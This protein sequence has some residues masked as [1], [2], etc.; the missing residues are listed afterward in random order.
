MRAGR[1]PT[2]R[3]I[4]IYT[5]FFKLYPEESNNKINFKGERRKNAN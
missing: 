5:R 3:F 2:P 1:S 4:T